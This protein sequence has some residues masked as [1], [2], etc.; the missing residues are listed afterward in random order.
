MDGAI[1]FVVRW[2]IG[3]ASAPSQG[4]TSYKVLSAG[5][6]GRLGVCAKRSAGEDEVRRDK[7]V[8]IKG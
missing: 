3:R 2:S 4:R 6:D 7:E 5:G 8:V 1:F